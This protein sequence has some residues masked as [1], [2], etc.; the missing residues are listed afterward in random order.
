MARHL[1]IPQAFRSLGFVLLFALSLTIA[2]DVP[3]GDIRESR[4]PDAF[5]MLGYMEIWK[6]LQAEEEQ[7]RQYEEAFRD[8]GF[9]IAGRGK[10]TDIDLRH[11]G[12]LVADDPPEPI[13][14]S[15]AA[16]GSSA[17]AVGPSGNS[18]FVANDVSNTV[19]ALAF[20][21]S[22]NRAT[23]APGSP[24]P[25]GEFPKA[26]AV[27]PTGRFLYVSGDFGTAAFRID[28]Q[29]AA[30]TPI[31]TYPFPG[32][33]PYSLAA[34]RSFV[35]VKSF[36]FTTSKTTIH[37]LGIDQAS[38]ALSSKS[39][40]E[41]T[42]GLPG[43]MVVTQ[44]GRLLYT[45]DNSRLAGF[46]VGSSGELTPLTNVSYAAQGAVT[47]MAVHPRRPYL[48][49][50]S[51]G[52]PQDTLQ[53]VRFDYL[54]G[55]AAP[56]GPAVAVDS[57]TEGIAVLPTGDSL[58]TSSPNTLTLSSFAVS[59]VDGTLTAIGS[60]AHLTDGG[61]S[62]AIR[63]TPG[64]AF[65][66]IGVDYSEPVEVRGGTPPYHFS[67]VEGQLPQG[68]TLDPSSGVLAGRPTQEQG[69]AFRIQVSDAKG[70]LSYQTYAMQ[71]ISPPPV[72]AAPDSL[73]AAALD[74]ATVS[75][76]W[77]DQAEGT[78]PF[79][80]ETSLDG[81]PFKEF[82]GTFP[83]MTSADQTGFSPATAY[84]FRVKAHS[85]GGDSAYSNVATVT[86]P[87]AAPT[88]CTSTATAGC[89]LNGRFKLEA[90][91]QTPQGL[92]GQAHVVPLTPDTAYLWFFTET[93]VEA[94]VKVLSTCGINAHY[95]VF[96]GG[97]TNVRVALKL[98]DAQTG[99]FRTYE[100]PI[101]NAFLPI[102]ETKA[103]GT[104]GASPASADE[105]SSS[106]AFEPPPLSEEAASWRLPSASASCTPG[107]AAMCLDGARFRVEATYLTKDGRTGPAHMVQVTP[108]T[109]YM[110]FFANTNVEAVVKV[111]SACG[112]NDHHWVF[113][114]GLTDVDVQLTVTDTVTQ[115]VKRYHNP[116]STPF[117]PVQDTTAFECP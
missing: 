103:F 88:P 94:V 60:P 106:P 105:A 57:D 47:A 26:I 46:V 74:P 78:A 71:T 66:G 53:A 42:T 99:A 31:A 30:L 37:V 15:G 54:T 8:H 97:L 62:L 36:D 44:E 117:Q 56:V 11:I 108:D 102:Q 83:F 63:Y 107:D 14:L 110:W 91:F 38:G 3:E 64:Q 109:G 95:W 89:V 17:L 29:T 55:S 79:V 52:S 12:N 50:S 93:N 69:A 34:S 90:M 2:G 18:V 45:G 76:S 101:D 25:V 9:L 13:G 1:G 104:C 43:P 27:E 80:L 61:N 51:F 33:F 116:Q 24:Y 5:E 40:Q 22:T 113:A 81:G 35:F 39:S 68:I 10:E 75:L 6:Q 4:N 59:R 41:Y 73:T 32:S 58:Y 85:T 20:D 70:S 112:V 82:E 84:G 7:W 100:N 72:P 92:V 77:H 96:A 28:V 16:A 111:L 98:T 86:T 19:S 65:A 48:Y 49:V 21:L 115:A 67:V 23:G 114:G 87:A